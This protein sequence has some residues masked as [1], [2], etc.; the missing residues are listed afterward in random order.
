MI[1]IPRVLLK[2][3]TKRPARGSNLEWL[4]EHAR[5]QSDDCLKWPFSRKTNG[6]GQINYLY[7]TTLAHRVMCL[8]AHGDAPSPAHQAAH[9]CGKGH[10]GC[11]NPRH[12]EWKTPRENAHDRILHG[13]YLAGEN[14]ATAKLT[15]YEAIAIMVLRNRM[16]QKDIAALFGV[17]S[18]AVANIQLGKTYQDL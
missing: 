8:I 18:T 10:E 15:K 1:A 13:T 17:S 5:H 12:L 7:R 4:F 14:G 16:E 2:T 6:Y 3:P 9:T 11:V